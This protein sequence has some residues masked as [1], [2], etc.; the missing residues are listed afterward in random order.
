MCILLTKLS[1]CSSQAVPLNCQVGGLPS[2]R[3]IGEAKRKG[4]D[5]STQ[6][7][8]F[9]NLKEKTHGGRERTGI[10]TFGGKAKGD[11]TTDQDDKK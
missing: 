4:K 1:Q 7:I 3:G 2:A 9:L 8:R 11:K 10:G 6:E 5:P